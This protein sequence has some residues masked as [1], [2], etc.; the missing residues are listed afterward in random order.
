MVQ[1]QNAILGQLHFNDLKKYV[2]PT[3]HVKLGTHSRHKKQGL[4]FHV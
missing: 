3:L 1:K 2:L 4:R